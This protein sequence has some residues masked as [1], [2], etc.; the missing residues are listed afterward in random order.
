MAE[1]LIS[2]SS[3][4][5]LDHVSQIY[6]NKQSAWT[7]AF[8]TAFRSFSDLYGDVV[9]NLQRSKDLLIQTASI[10]HFQEA[11]DAR[12]RTS[13]EFEAQKCSHDRQRRFFVIDWLSHVSCQEQHE[14]LRHKRRLY[15]ESTHWIFST[16]Q[17]IKW[18]S[19]SESSNPV[20]WIFGI[21]GAG[22]VHSVV[23]LVETLE[24]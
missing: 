13:Q 6:T 21:P 11:Q 22:R 24:C 23:A 1:L 19:G 15:P 4:V 12:V 8:K 3:E 10:W 2:S 7:I 16:A 17:F 20:L 5:C 18:S 14:E 9:K